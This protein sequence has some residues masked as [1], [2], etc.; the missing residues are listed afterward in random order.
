[1]IQAGLSDYLNWLEEIFSDVYSCFVAG[2]VV[3]LSGHDLHL[4]YL[5]AVFTEDDGEHPARAIRPFINLKTFEL[6][7][8]YREETA[9]LY[10]RWSVKLSAFGN[11][12]SFQLKPNGSPEKSKELEQGKIDLE[13]IV[14]IILEE[15]VKV[16]KASWSKPLQQGDHPVDLYKRFANEVYDDNSPLHRSKF[17]ALQRKDTSDVRNSASW[18]YGLRQLKDTTRPQPASLWTIVMNADGWGSGGGESDGN[19]KGIENS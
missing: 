15:M 17:E 7:D 10:A 13:N 16:E 11:P 8:T 3:G 18:L 6:L 1:L 2:T 12:G 5:P 4:D 19:S 9:A 14:I